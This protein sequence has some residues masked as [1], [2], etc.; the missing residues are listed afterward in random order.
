MK[1]KIGTTEHS[2]K[3]KQKIKQTK[4]TTKLAEK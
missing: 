4:T 3:L 2:M 1:E